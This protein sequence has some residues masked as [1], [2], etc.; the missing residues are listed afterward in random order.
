MFPPLE[1]DNKKFKAKVVSTFDLGFFLETEEGKTYQL[2]VPEMTEEF[3]DC[4]DRGKG[5]NLVGRV[6]EVFDSITFPGRVSQIEQHEINKR[7]E[8][9]RKLVE[10]GKIS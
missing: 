9:I 5:D 8:E 3:L 4:H 10:A 1:L 7:H 6:I 2:R